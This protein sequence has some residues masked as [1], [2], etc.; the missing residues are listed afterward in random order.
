MPAGGMVATGAGKA[1][2]G[3]VTSYVIISC[4][5]AAS[6]GALFGY[7]NGV[8]GGVVAMH[9]FL[10]KFFPEVDQVISGVQSSCTCDCPIE[11]S[12]SI[13]VGL[14]GMRM[15]QERIIARICRSWS[16]HLVGMPPLPLQTSCTH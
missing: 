2:A 14:P 4:I 10:R 1:Y 9:G 13:V 5:V 16:H 6:G 3:H 12:P 11:C 7:D 8:T 15:V